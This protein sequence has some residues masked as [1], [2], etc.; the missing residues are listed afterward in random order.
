MFSGC[1][2]FMSGIMCVSFLLSGMGGVLGCV[3]LLLILSRLVFLV[4]ICLVWCSVLLCV[5]KWL[6]LEN[7]LGVVLRMFIMSGCL[8]VSLKWLYWS[9]VG[10]NGD[11][12][13]LDMSNGCG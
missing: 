6:L 13:E 4:I 8:N 10:R 1:S 9:G 12:V 5:R 7:E 2:V 3:D 11:I